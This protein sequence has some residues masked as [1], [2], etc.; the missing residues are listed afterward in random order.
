[1]TI[2]FSRREFFGQ[3]PAGAVATLIAAEPPPRAWIIMQQGWEHNDEYSYTSGELAHSTLYYDRTA[4]EAACQ[5]LN[6][7][8]YANETPTEFDLD[9][10]LY[11]PQGLPA[12]QMEEDVTWDHVINAGW[13][14]IYFLR[15]LTIP[16]VT[17][18]E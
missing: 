2:P 7:E 9:W 13:D 8:F 6:D 14:D 12:G 16:G 18:D 4:A 15:E 3:A 1:M 10:F 5:K 11:F 17:A